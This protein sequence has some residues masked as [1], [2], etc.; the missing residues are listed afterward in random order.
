MA[1]LHVKLDRK[2]APAE[3]T[4]K[5]DSHNYP[6]ILQS[7]TEAFPAVDID[8]FSESNKIIVQIRDENAVQKVIGWIGSVFKYSFQS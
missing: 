2:K 7:T 1:K 3:L 8:T 4:I 6:T 5:C